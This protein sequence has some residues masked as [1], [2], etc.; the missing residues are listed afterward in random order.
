MRFTV[1]PFVIF[2]V[3]SYQ[4]I[5]TAY[6]HADEPRLNEV[7]CFFPIGSSPNAATN[8]PAFGRNGGNARFIF[9]AM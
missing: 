8:Y 6:V 2:I 9:I 3:G 5:A 1:A 7:F 4:C